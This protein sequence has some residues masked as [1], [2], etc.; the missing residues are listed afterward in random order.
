MPRS[1]KLSR[2]YSLRNLARYMLS[3]IYLPN[4]IATST[5]C[6]LALAKAYIEGIT[7]FLHQEYIGLRLSK[8]CLVRLHGKYFIVRKHT[9][10]LNFISPL[11]EN[12]EIKQSKKLCKLLR[13]LEPNRT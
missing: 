11:S 4:H 5:E 8:N 6:I 2:L 13:N 3:T 9:N 7:D 1:I 10:D 12:W